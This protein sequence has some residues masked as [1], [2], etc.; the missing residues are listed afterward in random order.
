MSTTADPYFT[1]EDRYDTVLARLADSPTLRAI[2][3]EVYGADYP[4]EADPFGFVTMSELAALRRILAGSGVTRL[5]D[6]GCGRGGPGLW[7]ARELGVPLTG[8]DIVA[9]AVAAARQQ[10]AAF[11]MSSRAEFRAASATDTG[12]PAAAF[13]G[14]VSIDAL[15]MI[16][17]KNAAF[18]ELARVLRAGSRLVFTT[19]EP[20][21]LDYSWYLEPAG[22]GDITKQVVPGSAAKQIAVYRAI[23]RQHAAITREMGAEAAAV[24]LAEAAETPALLETAP[25]M[26][27]TATRGH[28]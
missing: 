15:W 13:D 20:A 7:L 18:G 27:V 16:L 19:W 9:E 11:G 4:A 5:L 25:R 6:I 28:G 2:Y 23:A 22:F 21:H 3:L 8:V 26:I 14:A 17:D 12:L 24:L 10:A 1:R